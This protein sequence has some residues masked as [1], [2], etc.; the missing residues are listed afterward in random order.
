MLSLEKQNEWRDIFRQ[1]QPHWR[2][3]TEL[4]A[5]VVGS[6]LS[7]HFACL[8]LGCGRGGLVEQLGHPLEKIVGVDPDFDSLATHRLALAVVQGFSDGLPFASN[9]F[10]VVFA[11]W[12]LEHL[13]RPSLTLQ[14]IYH[15]LKPGGVFI[16]ITPNGR[17]PLALLNK[18]FGKM[19]T[20]QGILVEKLY[21]RAERDTFP[22]YYRANDQHTIATLARQSGLTVREL[23]T[24]PDPTYLAFTPTAFKLS[25]WFEQQLPN[26][27][28]IHLVGVLEKGA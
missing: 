10:D 11:S 9:S 1:K 2:P 6:C 7:P 5:D 27:R 23:H 15:C 22:T 4:F 13:E 28:K 16:F 19:L 12:V 18:L 14:S 8:D 26:E 25:C 17:H 20:I 24:I 21:K 3:A